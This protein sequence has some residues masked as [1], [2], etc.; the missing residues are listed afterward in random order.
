MGPSAIQNVQAVLAAFP[1]SGSS[2]SRTKVSSSFCFPRAREGRLGS[3]PGHALDAAFIIS[4][5]AAAEHTVCLA[6]AAQ[7]GLPERDMLHFRRRRPQHLLARPGP[8]VSIHQRLDTRPLADRALLNTMRPGPLA[9]IA[10]VF[11]PNLR[12]A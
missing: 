12:R 6:G 11:A 7:L 5:P 3:G 10:A 4:L 2:Q 8:V 1:A 9:R